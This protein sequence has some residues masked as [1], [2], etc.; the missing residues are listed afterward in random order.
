MVLPPAP[1]SNGQPPGMPTMDP[2]MAGPMP[3]GQASALPTD[4]PSPFQVEPPRFSLPQP[5]FR[6]DRFGLPTFNSDGSPRYREKKRPDEDQ[7]RQIRDQRTAFWTRRNEEIN[8][9]LAI[10]YM[11]QAAD[12]KD[13][14]AAGEEMIQRATGAA[15]VYKIA[16]MMSAQ[17][18]VIKVQPLRDAAPY[19]E[20][21]QAIEDFLLDCRR[22]VDKK[23]TARGQPGYA[24][25]E[26]WLAG[27]TGWLVS[28][29]YL[30]LSRRWLIGSE[31]YDPRCCY[32]EYSDDDYAQLASMLYYEETT[33]RAF[34]GS[35][36]RFADHDA[37]S[38]LDDDATATDPDLR[39]CW[40]EDD[41]Y[42]VIMVN[43]DE[44]VIERHG[45]GFCPWLMTAIGGTPL[46][47]LRS[48]PFRGMSVVRLL[49]PMLRYR[50]RLM[51]QAAVSTP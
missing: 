7:I 26:G 43:D 41:E 14:D 22:H 16:Q 28:R 8:K 33:L 34:L 35:N 18:D 47:D 15:M 12:S 51:S 3:P 49:R 10:V 29:E 27:A 11:E 42:S 19:I 21:A 6:L 23:H 24:F 36:P 13:G 31:L 9:D 48:R 30:D 1:P 5:E 37:F 44:P 25:S 40:Y 50:D 4:Q 46:M 38:D 32:P 45:Y 2:M 17:K 39:I 20:A